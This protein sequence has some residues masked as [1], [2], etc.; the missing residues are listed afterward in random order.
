MEVEVAVT[1]INMELE[2][3]ITTDDMK[4]EAI[5]AANVEVETAAIT[6][7]LELEATTITNVDV[8]LL[9]CRQRPLLPICQR[10]AVGS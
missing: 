10:G 6:F 9:T 1:T 3:T 4:P 2:A 5:A 7:K 8:L